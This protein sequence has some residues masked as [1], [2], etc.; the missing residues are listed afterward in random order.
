MS[1]ARFTTPMTVVMR[2][3]ALAIATTFALA[4]TAWSMDPTHAISQ[5]G[6]RVWR[7][8]EAG[9]E[10][11][12]TSMAQTTDGQLWVG[13]ADGLYKFD[14]KRFSRW[15]QAGRSPVN[16]GY[17]NDL[18]GSRDG[19][20]YIGSR[21]GLS[22][23]SGEN[24]RSYSEA[25]GISGTFAQDSSGIVWVTNVGTYGKESLCAIMQTSL[26]CYKPRDGVPCS[27]NLGVANDGPELWLAGP[28]GICRWS[29][30]R[31]SQ[32]YP[33]GDLNAAATDITIDV[34]HVLW[35]SVAAGSGNTGLWRFEAGGWKRF[36]RP[37]FDS[38]H[39][40]ICCLRGDQGGSLWL[41]TSRHGIYRITQGGVDRFDH[42]DGLS[43]DNV[44]RIFVDHEGSTWIVT[45]R[46]IDQLFDLPI[47]RFSA[48]EGLSSD[49]VT[50][51]S[52]ETPGGE[53]LTSE[54]TEIDSI[55]QSGA[56]KRFAKVA[57]DGN[58]GQVFSDSSGRVWFATHTTLVMFDHS[59]IHHVR[60]GPR[61]APRQ[62]F[63]MAEDTHHAL[64]VG[65]RDEEKPTHGWLWRVTQGRQDQRILS[66]ANGG[67]G[68]IFRIAS[69]LAGGL[70]AATARN[71]FYHLEDAK[72]TQ[73]SRMDAVASKGVV[74]IAPVA[75]GEAW[76]ATGQG[77]AWLRRGQPLVLNVASGLPCDRLYS[78]V[79]DKSDDLWLTAQCGL[80]EVSAAELSRWKSRPGYHVHATVFGTSSGYFGDE[81]SHLVRATDGKLWFAGSTEAYEIDPEHI[82]VNKSAPPVQIQGIEADRRRYVGESKVVLPKLTR[83]LEI[84]YAGLSYLQPD[85]LRF[86]Y[87]LFNHDREWADVGS[88]RQAYYND[89]PPGSYRFQ[90]TA[91]N[92]DGVCNERGAS[93]AILI[94]PAWWQTWWFKALGVLTVFA[95]VAAV[96]RW[97]LTAFAERTRVRFDDRLQER[98][99]VARDL[100][101]TLMQTVLAS[102]LLADGAGTAASDPE[103]KAAFARLSAWLGRAA[104]EGRTAVEALRG[105]SVQANG[106]VEA[107][108][109]VA[110]EAQTDRRIDIP[111]LLTGEVR[112]LHPVVRQEV[113]RIGVEA[114]RNACMHSGATHVIVS[115]TYHQSLTL[116][117]CDD[118]KGIDQAVLKHGKAGH[119]GLVGMRERATQVGALLT[120]ASS[121]QGTEIT[122]VVPGRSAFIRGRGLGAIRRRSRARHSELSPLASDLPEPS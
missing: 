35:T 88:R 54:G 46:G 95:L 79:L 76:V 109:A 102:K 65:G 39:L 84:D 5:Y 21:A 38:R 93:V 43:G 82:Q 113:H 71:A 116:S 69:D 112:E 48:R 120:V 119:F 87:R 30:G 15:E 40:N 25:A 31:Q 8:G 56:V 24:Y 28:S 1:L 122:L 75:P 94:P 55:S 61:D 29:P 26:K 11:E 62:V 114:I 70:W 105:S 108:E 10:H 107:F 23:V 3:W 89:L 63:S 52:A 7:V 37:G 53:V 4:G 13:T 66:P 12:P 106:L 59:G 118:G 47:V 17:V 98:T 117:V 45:S 80:I 67:H 42:L 16:L 6:H 115:L 92:K 58:V 22:R 49:D 64:W 86:R 60:I 91:C 85:L 20:L 19:S 44:A 74:D 78:L 110:L 14:G 100:H 101:D 121:T 103:D 90:V 99:R 34:H 77:A 111:V 33:L 51:V 73:I 104:D 27:E 50:W 32:V 81:T 83:N 36:S 68:S 18:F 96:L 41:G 57:G 97:R 2:T 9:L 72:F